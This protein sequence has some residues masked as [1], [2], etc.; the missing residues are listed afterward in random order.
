VV[1][2]AFGDLAIDFDAYETWL[3]IPADL[4]P[5][6]YY[7]LLGLAY[8]EPD[9]AA[10]EI[11]ALRRMGKVRL[12][13]DG[14]HGDR[15]PELLAELQK[16][17]SILIDSELRAEYDAELRL[18]REHRPESASPAEHARLLDDVIALPETAEPGRRGKRGGSNIVKVV[19]LL[20]N[21]YDATHSAN[22]I[23]AGCSPRHGQSRS[24][25]GVLRK[26]DGL[27]GLGSNPGENS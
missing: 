8:H 26:A 15:V 9:L 21:S 25:D 22:C 16:A 6:T 19:N 17:R 14:E 2:D 18:G 13:Q 20:A 4:R 7:D 24:S 3:G 11:A 27:P 5:Y 12:H 23:G 1:V 10:I